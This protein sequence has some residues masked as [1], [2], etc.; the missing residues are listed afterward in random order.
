MIQF[1]MHQQQEQPHVNQ[2]QT[3]NQQHLQYQQAA[4]N[5]QQQPIQQNVI[6]HQQS[7]IH[8]THHT[9][10][11]N[12]TQANQQQNQS[13]QFDALFDSSKTTAQQSNINRYS[14]NNVYV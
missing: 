6:V 10:P 12:Q 3:P 7:Q 1:E 9:H 14:N 13:S 11:V 2:Y 4:L 5:Q 8:Q